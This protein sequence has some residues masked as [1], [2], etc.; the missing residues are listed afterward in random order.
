MSEEIVN[1]TSGVSFTLSFFF[2]IIVN[3][4]FPVTSSPTSTAAKDP[5]VVISDQQE[6]KSDQTKFFEIFHV[7]RIR[8]LPS[9][10]SK[11]GHEQF[12]ILVMRNF[13]PLLN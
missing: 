5:T 9:N 6:G 3:F 11:W 13:C 7:R 2:M 10:C 4:G 8:W 12:I 1:L